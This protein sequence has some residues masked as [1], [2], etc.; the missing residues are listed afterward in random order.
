MPC[1]VL[2]QPPGLELKR[3]GFDGVFLRRYLQLRAGGLVLNFGRPWSFK[4][5]KPPNTGP[6]RKGISLIVV[7]PSKP[8]STS[9]VVSYFSKAR[10]R[11][12]R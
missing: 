1:K 11:T 3:C 9:A 10:L 4:R 7:K 5:L 6:N 8:E 2:F 12:P